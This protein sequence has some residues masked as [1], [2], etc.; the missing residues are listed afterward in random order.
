M[1][2]GC[3]I[4]SG[5]R[6]MRTARIMFG[7]GCYPEG[8][9]FGYFMAGNL[10]VFKQLFGPEK[11]NIEVFCI[12]GSDVDISKFFI[13]KKEKKYLSLCLQKTNP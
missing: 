13:G 9:K 10:L 7:S 12:Q 4:S 3:R 5:N 11:I 1:N 6:S 8:I 2:P